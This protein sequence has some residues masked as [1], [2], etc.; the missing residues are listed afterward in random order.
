MM[1]CA[2]VPEK[3]RTGMNRECSFCFGASDG[4]VHS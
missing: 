1:S 4:M 2:D 3:Y